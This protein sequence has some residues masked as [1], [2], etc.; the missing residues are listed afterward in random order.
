M[1]NITIKEIA[2]LAGVSIGTVDRVIHNR[3]HVDPDKEKRI[4]YICEQTGYQPNALA[5]A[6]TMRGK[7]M[8][9]AV[10]INHPERN[11]FSRRVKEGVDAVARDL[12]DYN[13][14]IEYFF[15]SDGSE[16]E[17]LEQLAAVEAGDFH[18]LIV[19]P[20]QDEQVEMVLRRMIADGLPVVTCTSDMDD[21]DTIGFV[22]QDHNS[23]GRLAANMLWTCFRRSIR[24]AVLS[25]KKNVLSRTQ[26]IDSFCDYMNKHGSQIVDV[27]EISD[28]PEVMYQQ[29]RQILKQSG[30]LD[31]L[32]VHTGD[33][34]PV[35]R[36]VCD[37]GLDK[38]LCMFTFADRENAVL[39]MKGCSLLFVIEENPY[40]HG[41]L[42]CKTMQEYLLAQKRP[43]NRKMLIQA[44]ILLEESL[45]KEDV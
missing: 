23:E 35:H 6:L 9:V 34:M 1:A 26:K 28:E 25:Q 30:P 8:R 38:K 24:I 36:A 15:L 32:Y 18:G 5:R 33:I 41:Y 45:R 31:A 27:V 21:L 39:W 4:R 14:T 42:A 2:R 11:T 3:G 44:H 20:I 40:Q 7:N 19:K 37:A 16:N 22:G 13:M 17:L 43:E 10:I 12:K 29:A